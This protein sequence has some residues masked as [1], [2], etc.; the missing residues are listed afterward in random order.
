MFLVHVNVY[1]LFMN[2]I[3]FYIT[4]YLLYDYIIYL[5]TDRQ[6]D[7]YFIVRNKSHYR[8]ICHSNKRD[9]CAC[10]YKNVSLLKSYKTIYMV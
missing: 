5:S 3:L 7:R 10:I 1:R 2:D 6:A 4:M 9:I 8:R